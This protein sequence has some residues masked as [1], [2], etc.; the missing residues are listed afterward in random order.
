M[1]TKTRKPIEELTEAEAKD[2]LARLAREIAENDRL[3]YEEAAPVLSD[4]EYDAMW[5]RNLA[6]EQRFPQLKRADSPSSRVSGAASEKFEKVTHRVPVL[7]LD[8]AFTDEDVRDFVAR[9]RR[10]LKVSDGAPVAFT[11]EP[12]KS[13][14]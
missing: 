3:Y 2:E 9:V 12:K 6:I 4:A 7:S 5:R 13:S 14:A 11:A 10:F 8:N 1:S